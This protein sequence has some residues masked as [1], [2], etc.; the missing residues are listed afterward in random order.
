MDYP[1]LGAAA[2]RPRAATASVLPPLPTRYDAVARFL[3]W[4]TALLLL[5]VI[6]LAWQ[7]LALPENDPRA[8][9]YFTL[10]KSIGVT[11]LALA[12]LRLAWR[13]THPA[14]PLPAGTPRWAVAAAHASHWLLYL[15]LLAMPISGYV[16]TAAAGYPVPWFGLFELPTLPRN[17]ALANAANAAHLAG[18][19]V[20]YALVVLHVLGVV[21]HV[22]I[23]RDGLL[24]RMLPP[25]EPL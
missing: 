16:L 7:M 22:V 9:L 2:P 19:W 18:Q 1:T 23:W 25:Q 6:P 15:A 12:A 20:V 14:P 4:L 13:A 24:G 3:H 21:W 11:I 5:A 17:E 10:H 8:G